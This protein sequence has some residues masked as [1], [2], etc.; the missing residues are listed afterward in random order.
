LTQIHPDISALLVDPIG[1]AKMGELWAQGG[2]I[3]H[4]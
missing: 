3:D 2:A 4:D 1:E